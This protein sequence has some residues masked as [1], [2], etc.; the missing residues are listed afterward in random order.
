MT[1]APPTAVQLAGCTAVTQAL[2]LLAAGLPTA[3]RASPR[4]AGELCID[5]SSG[6]RGSCVRGPELACSKLAMVGGATSTEMMS[7]PWRCTRCARLSWSACFPR[8]S[9]R[10]DAE[11][12]LSIEPTVTLTPSGGSGGSTTAAVMVATAPSW[13]DVRKELVLVR[14]PL[15]A[16]ATDSVDARFPEVVSPEVVS[17]LSRSSVPSL[18]TA[19]C[20]DCGSAASNAACRSRSAFAWAR[21]SSASCAS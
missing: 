18:D 17:G 19:S 15:V 21:R 3:G 14:T 10:I 8:S 13:L 1:A 6:D 20:A 5:R 2:L 12:P 16:S 4:P 9:C 7:L 11:A